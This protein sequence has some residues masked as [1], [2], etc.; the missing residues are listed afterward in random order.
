MLKQPR[1]VPQRIVVSTAE[2]V[3]QRYNF[4]L[5]VTCAPRWAAYVPILRLLH[6]SHRW[7]APGSDRVITEP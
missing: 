2:R 4:S 1:S 5:V 7:L 6:P 3:L